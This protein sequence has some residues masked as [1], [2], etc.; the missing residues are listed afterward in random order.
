MKILFQ[1]PTETE[2]ARFDFYAEIMRAPIGDIAD[3]T[4]ES[5]AYEGEP[6][7]MA[8]VEATVEFIHSIDLIK[9]GASQEELEARSP[10][11]VLDD[12][13][14]IRAAIGLIFL[15]L[16]RL[17]QA[18]TWEDARAVP[19]VDTTWVYEGVEATDDAPKD[20]AGG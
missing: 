10:L 14:K 19:F 20:V 6:V 13:V 15:A 2:P 3:M 1:V 18:A 12:P 16:R 5:K 4:R 8:Q 17:N 7:S 9:N 11:Q